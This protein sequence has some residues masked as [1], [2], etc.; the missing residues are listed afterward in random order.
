MTQSSEYLL[1][2]TGM[3]KAFPGVLATD[4]VDLKIRPGKYMH[5][6]ARMVQVNQPW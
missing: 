6:W 5:Y 3:R 4:N 1:E 2:I